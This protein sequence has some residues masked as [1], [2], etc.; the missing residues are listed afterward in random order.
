MSI[1]E[2]LSGIFEEAFAALGLPAELGLVRVSDRLEMAE[3]QCNGAMPAAKKAEKNPREIAQ[4]IIDHVKDNPA[5]R[6]L[7]IG[8]PGFIN[9]FI[10]DDFLKNHLDD[11]SLPSLSEGETVVLDYGG[12][13]IAK[14]MHVGHLRTGII[15]DCLRRLLK[16]V[17]FNALGD[18]HMGDWGTHM[19][20]LMMDYIRSGKEALVMNCDLGDPAAV[21]ALFDDMAERYPKAS[22]AAKEESSLMEE[23][24]AATVKLQNGEEPFTSM[25]QKIR[26]VSISA[27]E[28]NYG[29]LNVHF[30][31]WKG[32]ADV[33]HLIAPMAEGLKEKGF[34]VQDEGA[35]VI[36]VEKNDDKKKYPP[37]ILY[38]RDGGVMYGTTDMATVVERVDLYHPTR[39]IYIVD[40]RQSLHFEQLFR[41]VRLSDIVS[42][43]V[44][45][46]FAGVGT[47]N[48]TDGKPF[49]TRAGG[50]MRLSDMIDLARDKAMERLNEADLAQ[51]MSEEERKDIAHKV[52]VAALKFADLQNQRHADYIFDLDRMTNFEG[53]TGPYLLYQAVRIKSLLRKAD[54]NGIQADHKAA[55]IIEDSAK[56][57]LL[58]LTQ[59]P[60]VLKLAVRNYTPHVLCDYVYNLA[61]A[62]SSFYGNSQVL[63]EENESL[64]N[65]R[66]MICLLVLQRLEQVLDLL[67][68]DIPE[69]M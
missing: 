48:G 59:L 61:Q 40:Q 16:S 65:T 42:D 4:S 8:G 47:M 68:V 2:A 45:L 41:A 19:G 10:T 62:F 46:T 66:L 52:G 49:K 60:D 25:W 29:K 53:K 5:F 50:V 6:E 38:K 37:L 56:P 14:P 3:F 11:M 51:D 36:P 34:A 58:L 39:I 30:D 69:R 64:R 15:G 44:E 63:G 27:M 13:N 1:T 18:V 21:Q 22:A 33:H 7:S 31:L 55:F 9:I 12:P 20:M 57:L 32:E 54:E 17:G 43:D 28:R 35:W 26:D 24:R 67:G 23:A